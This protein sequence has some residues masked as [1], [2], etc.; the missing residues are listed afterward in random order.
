MYSLILMFHVATM[1]MSLVLMGGAIGM[2]LF[3]QQSSVK[4]ANVGMV[5]TLSG[6]VSGAVLLLAVPLSFK[7]LTLTAYLIGMVLLYRYGFGMGNIKN[8]RLIRAR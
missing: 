4:V 1:I 2:A 7:C 3:G 5:A 8:A 6:I